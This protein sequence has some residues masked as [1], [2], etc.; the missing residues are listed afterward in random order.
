MTVDTTANFQEYA[1]KVGT[2]NIG[3]QQFQLC[4]HVQKIE[5]KYFATAFTKTPHDDGK[6]DATG[7]YYKKLAAAELAFL[8]QKTLENAEI[9]YDDGQQ[10]SA[11]IDRLI[12]AIT[13]MNKTD[14]TDV[15]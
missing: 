14:Y 1:D 12:K 15:A 5:G 9:V 11:M 10:T 3:D 7:I 8:P 4:D 6:D 13:N 2:V